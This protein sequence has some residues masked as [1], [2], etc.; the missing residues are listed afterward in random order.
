MFLLVLSLFRRDGYS[1]AILP[2]IRRGP[3]EPFG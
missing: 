1:A 3:R 2:S